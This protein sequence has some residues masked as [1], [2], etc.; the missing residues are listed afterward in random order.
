MDVLSFYFVLA[1]RVMSEKNTEKLY[2]TGQVFSEPRCFIT[3]V[4]CAG[5]IM[6]QSYVSISHTVAVSPPSPAPP[7][8]AL[9]SIV[10]LK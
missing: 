3:T 2:N 5:G 7:A 10:Y 1:S 8:L 4:P 9:S 6:I